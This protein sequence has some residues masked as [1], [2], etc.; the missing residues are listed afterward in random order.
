MGEGERE[1]TL[2][3]IARVHADHLSPTG[4]ALSVPAPTLTKASG[5]YLFNAIQP[6]VSH[7]TVAIAADFGLSLVTI[8]DE[9]DRATF[10]AFNEKAMWNILQ[11]TKREA[12]HSIPQFD[13][14]FLMELTKSSF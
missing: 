12:K 14:A 2:A 5:L 10:T 11:N 8:S 6:W 3:S 13:Y 7:P 4:H 1:R 9:W